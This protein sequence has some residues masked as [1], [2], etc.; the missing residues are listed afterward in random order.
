MDNNPLKQ[1]FRRP[2]VYMKLP[3]NGQG[4][5]EEALDMPETGELPVYP[6]T[7]IDE[8]TARTPD[9]LFNGTAIAE[10]ITSCVPNIKDPWAV[11]NVDLDAILIAIKT[12]SS[13]SGEMDL[14]SVCP[15]CGDSSTYKINLAGILASISSPD[16]SQELV[17]GDLKV[18]LKSVN[19]KEINA[20]SMKQFEFQ[21]VADQIDSIESEEDR[22]KLMKDSLQK[23]TDLTMDL[24]CQAIEYI[25][26]PTIKVDQKDYILDFLRHCDRNVYVT[27]RDRSS[28][29]RQVSE[30]KPM[31]ITCGSCEHKYEQAITLNPTDFFE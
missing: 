14:E 28:E 8:I 30:V 17:T 22:N 29:L 15:N 25:Q 13:S 1:Y 20:A 9:A 24:L 7:A 11:P 21:R 10:L 2:S 4:Y 16:F 19:F 23:V 31:K 18:K 3:S 26:T 27:I 5:P 6:M 12:A